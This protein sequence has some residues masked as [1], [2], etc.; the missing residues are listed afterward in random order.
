MLDLEQVYDY[1]FTPEAW[2]GLILC[3]NL[4]SRTL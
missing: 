4:T 2:R 3:N 1:L